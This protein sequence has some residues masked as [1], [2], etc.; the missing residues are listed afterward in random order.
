[1]AL[2]IILVSAIVGAGLYALGVVSGWKFRE[3]AE[4]MFVDPEVNDDVKI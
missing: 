4:E 2:V 3:Y 1:M